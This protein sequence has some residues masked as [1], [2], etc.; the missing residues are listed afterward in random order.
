MNDRKPKRTRTDATRALIKQRALERG[1]ERSAE[2]EQRVRNMM[3]TIEGEMAGNEGIYPHNRGALSA[4]ELARRVGIHATTFFTENQRELG[5]DVKSWVEKI[6]TAN[7]VGRVPIRRNL[8]ERLE[9][10]K[11]LYN[12]LTQSHRDTELELQQKEAELAEA[13][14][15][16]E[17]LKG[18][19]DELRA[20]LA[21]SGREK[22]VPIRRKRS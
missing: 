11:T 8:S 3:A 19:S 6:K 17:R 22:V 18:E 13:A 9:D 7:V 14:R 16:I 15:E 10:W 21:R 5:S 12:G 4:A 20:F 1:K 2:V